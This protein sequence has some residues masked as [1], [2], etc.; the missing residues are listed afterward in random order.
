MVQGMFLNYAL[1]KGF[2]KVGV[3]N[4]DFT[5]AERRSALTPWN[6]LTSRFVLSKDSASCGSRGLRAEFRL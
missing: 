3:D 1:S 5:V 2:W 6:L 4:L